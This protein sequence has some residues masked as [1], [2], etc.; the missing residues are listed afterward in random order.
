[1]KIK[2]TFPI[3]FNLFNKVTFVYRILGKKNPSNFFEPTPKNCRITKISWKH[4][5]TGNANPTIFV[6]LVFVS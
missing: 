6:P 2:I 5:S 1:M 4:N 3:S